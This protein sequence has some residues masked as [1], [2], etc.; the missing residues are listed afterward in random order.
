[1]FDYF[2]NYSSNV[3]VW[4]M[5]TTARSPPALF[6][7]CGLKFAVKIVGLKVCLTIA[8]LITLTFIQGHMCVSGLTTF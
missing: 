6:C 7:V 3:C 1:M 5:N 8:S 2:R 4:P